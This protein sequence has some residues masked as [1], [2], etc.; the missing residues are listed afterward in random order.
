M[1]LS[2]WTTILTIFFYAL[3]QILVIRGI[4][5]SLSLDSLPL[6]WFSS[7]HRLEIRSTRTVKSRHCSLR[8][9]TVRNKNLESSILRMLPRISRQQNWFW[10]EEFYRDF[11]TWS[12]RLESTK[13]FS[14]RF[15]II[16]FLSGAQSSPIFLSLYEFTVCE[17][18]QK[19]P[20]WIFTPKLLLF[21]YNLEVWRKNSKLINETFWSDFQTL[22]PTANSM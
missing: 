8:H 9:I 10:L 21:D 14:Y 5:D 22:C 6:S 11:L 19:C 13:K 18:Y 2:P 20:I 1:Q 12:I 15:P 7:N 17:N 16:G 3:S 4:L